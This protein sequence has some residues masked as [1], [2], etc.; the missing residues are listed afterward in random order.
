[1]LWLGTEG[2]IAIA[3]VELHLNPTAAGAALRLS[4]FCLVRRP[5][6][7]HWS[8]YC[9]DKFNHL[10]PWYTQTILVLMLM[11]YWCGSTDIRM[12]L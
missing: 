6:I 11:H 10:S 3:E 1:M 12:T 9:P 7:N 4:P 8:A 2:G 5:F